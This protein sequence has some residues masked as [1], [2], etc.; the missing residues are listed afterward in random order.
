[1]HDDHLNNLEEVESL[2][3][4]GMR[5]ASLSVS[6]QEIADDNKALIRDLSSYDPRTAIPLLASLLTIPEYQSQCIRLEI[7]VALAVVFCKGR[8]KPNFGQAIRWFS[9]IG[10][11]RC[12][13]GEDPAEDVFVSLVHDC[14]GNYRLLEG[15]WEAA[16]FYTQRVL[17]VISTMPD[18]GEFGQIKRSFRALLIISE[19]ICQKAGLQRYQLGS[20]EYHDTLHPLKN[21]KFNNL[22]SKV[23]IT[24]KELDEKG[25]SPADIDPFIFYPRMMKNLAKQQIGASDLDRHPLIVFSKSHLTVAL[26]SALSVAVRD[27]AIATIING[28]LIDAFDS[29]LARHYAELFSETPLLGGPMRAPVRWQKVGRHRWSNFVFEVDQGYFISYHLFLASVEVHGDSGFKSIYQDDGT[30]TEV[31]QA[32]INNIQKKF[33]ARSDFKEGLFCIVGC[34]WGKGYEIQGIQVDHP[35]WRCQSMS[36]ADLIRISYLGDMSP[37]YFWRIQ[38]GLETIA[39][40]GIH[41]INPNGI[42]NLIGWIRSNDGHFV[43]HAQLPEGEISPEKPLR[44]PLPTNLLRE[45]RADSDLGYDRHRT[46]D[47]IGTWHDVQH[48][49]PNPIFHSA[50]ERRVY[51]SM[52]HVRNG[53]LT[54]VY[55]GVFQLWVSLIVP[56]LT[57]H[58]TEYRLWEMANEW[59][60]RIGNVLDELKESFKRTAPLKVY[61]EFHD[62]DPSKEPQLK[63]STE[64]LISYC[65]IGEHGEPNACKAIFQEGF[66]RGFAIAENIAE[67]LFVFNVVRAF[68]HLLHIKNIDKEAEAIT[69]RVVLNKEA[70]SFHIFHAQDFTHYVRDTLPKKLITI[71]PID[72]AAAKIGLGWRILDRGKENKIEERE[73]CTQFL[74]KV[75]EAL[76][77]EIRTTLA[78]FERITTVKRLIANSEKANAEHDHW[79]RTSAALIGLHNHDDDAIYRCVEQLSKFSGAGVPSRA[80]IE[81]ALCICPHE[82][83]TQISDI[84]LSKLL[85]RA[86]LVIRIGGLSD[87]IYYNALA[88]E[89]KISPLG[90]ILF[91]DDFGQLVVQPM[92]SRAIGDKFIA[93]APLQ[94][95]NYDDPEAITTTKGIISDEFWNIWKKEMGFDLDEARHIIG[96][97]ED[98]GIADHTAILSISQSEYFSCVCSDQ[99]SKNTAERFLDQFSLLPR[100]RW[101][102]P[103][104]GFAMKDIYP[105]RFGRRLS[106]VTR[107]ILQVDHSDDSLLI[108]APGALRKGFAYVFDG[109]YR[110]SLEQSFFKS[111]EM[112]N[113]WWGKAGEGHSFNA[114]VARLLSNAGWQKRENIGLPEL[115]SR[116]MDRDFGDI[117]VIAWRSDRKEVLVIECKDLSLARNYSEIAALLSD[118][119]GKDIGGKPDSLKKHLNRVAMLQENLDQLRQFTGIQQ[120][121]IVSCL[122]CSGIVPMQYAKIDALANTHVGSIEDILTL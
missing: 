40:A 23:K 52:D 70:R 27:Y 94:K 87:A 22:A 116:K 58:N 121:K 111:D 10:K 109:A 96:A 63:P 114:H 38:D 99:V 74:N 5:W 45:V 107:P 44:L 36:V 68:L 112:R 66:L 93:S 61:I 67:R 91:R 59:L 84:E 102:K 82:E 69:Q 16:G 34:G 88:P 108:I 29:M 71:D 65:L 21:L 60:H 78:S 81:I 31:L 26:P 18:D 57:S 48:V 89:L 37:S 39:R 100:Q 46:L 33:T 56:E 7:L 4:E 92:L 50:S 6:I 42:L 86:S 13:A 32:S 54:S 72:D 28:N 103:P 15:V 90:D 62:T 3:A 83:G 120:P 80:L 19:I 106:F 35:K 17:D 1:M 55:E 43:S 119:Q 11:S 41:I 30:F 118:Y 79:E 117:D 47:N 110:G 105:W 14:N 77:S 101:D 104:K 2:I 113:A 20:D 49:S 12:V 9:L 53:V 51:A 75:V 25:V 97:L 8:K 24:F 85:A 95:K 76:L 73:A 98:K 64:E 122:V 115:L